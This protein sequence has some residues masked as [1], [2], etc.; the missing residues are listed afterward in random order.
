MTGS[1]V[2]LESCVDSVASARVAESGGAGRVELCA[3]LAQGGTTP[4]AG[5]IS[6]CVEALHIPVVVMIRPRGGDFLY[7]SEE[8]DV[9]RRDIRTARTLE[10]DGIACGVLRADGTVDIDAMRLLLDEAGP[11]AMTFHRAFDATS[12]LSRSLDALLALGIPRVLTSGGRSTA[13]EATATIRDLVRH[14]GDAI[15]IMAGG[16]VRANNVQ[17]LVAGT[18]V[19]EVHARIVNRTESAMSFR[20]ASL[21]IARTFVPDAYAT[22][23]TSLEGVRELVAA[24]RA[25]SA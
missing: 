19:R 4:S 7:D 2:L 11:L 9:M 23:A 15:T 5:T 1:P 12:D 3:D 24:L 18:G 25:P 8:L 13:V 16:G 6:R 14:A 21:G 20:A 10:A 22:D 17:G